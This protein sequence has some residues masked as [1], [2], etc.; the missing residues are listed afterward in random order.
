M[1][2]P[3]DDH[4][5]ALKT[6]LRYLKGTS[7][8]GGI[9]PRPLRITT[10]T[11]FD[12][13]MDANERKTSLGMV[14]YLG[15]NLVSWASKKQHVVSRSNTEAEYRALALTMIEIMWMRPLLQELRL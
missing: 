7:T 1:H 8:H 12:W 9:L 10:I 6:I 2:D 15:E 13:G 4:W 14:V 3:S 11:D 5:K